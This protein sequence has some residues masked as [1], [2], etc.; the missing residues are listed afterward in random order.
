MLSRRSLVVAFVLSAALVAAQ[1]LSV[2]YLFGHVEAL[3]GGRWV[4]LAPG[5][6]VDLAAT[7]R[8]GPDSVLELV[9]GSARVTLAAPGSYE[10]RD[11]IAR[12]ASGDRGLAVFLRSAVRTLLAS[13]KE[14]GSPLG[15][16]AGEIKNEPSAWVDEDE[17]ALDKAQSLLREGRVREAQELL[18]KAR[19]QATVTGPFDFL[20]AYTAALEGKAGIAL[21][22]LRKAAIEGSTRYHEEALAL[23]AELAL[24]AEAPAE[25]ASAARAYLSEYASGARAQDCSLIEGLALRAL[26]ND[27][28]SRAALERAVKMG[29]DSES[30]RLAAR[31]LRR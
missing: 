25:A 10:V 9:S 30:G 1:Q 24:E 19:Q 2:D 31:E 22:L 28:G 8:L 4:T 3:Q 17:V 29:P 5:A 6:S 20:I 14:R 18:L 13:P 11:V 27:A 23:R 16:R 26:G 21:G 15:A 7:L 12:R